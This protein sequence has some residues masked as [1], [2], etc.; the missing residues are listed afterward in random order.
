VPPKGRAGLARSSVKGPSRPPSPPAR[1][2]ARTRP[3][4]RLR[5][6][7]P[8]AI[9][10]SKA[11]GVDNRRNVTCSRCETQPLRQ[12]RHYECEHG[13][14]QGVES[15]LRRAA[16]STSFASSRFRMASAKPDPRGSD[17]LVRLAAG[18]ADSRVRIS[19]PRDTRAATSAGMSATKAST[20][21]SGMPSTRARTYASTNAPCDKRLLGLGA[22]RGE[23]P[24]GCL[25]KRLNR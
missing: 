19:T 6:D 2:S 9:E 16:A 15:P 25:L 22:S 24:F 12:F 8:N 10:Q 3:R 21:R 7:G 23:V 18:R 17:R 1:I 4:R 13:E 20:L 5:V 14:D 11:Q